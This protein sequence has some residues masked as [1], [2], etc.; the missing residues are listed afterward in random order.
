MGFIGANGGEVGAHDGK[1]C[2]GDTSV[3]PGMRQRSISMSRLATETARLA[4]QTG[5]ELVVAEGGKGDD[6][7]PMSF[8]FR[9]ASWD[10][11]TYRGTHINIGSV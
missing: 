10:Q 3:R 8:A 4:G 6:L 7:V 2:N 5:D 11:C 1:G 9:S